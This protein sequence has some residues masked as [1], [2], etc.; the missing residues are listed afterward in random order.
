[1]TVSSDT[2]LAI[3]DTL[4]QLDSGDVK[5]NGFLHYKQGGNQTYQCVTYGIGMGLPQ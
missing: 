5:P 1:M 3:G 2:S 4:T